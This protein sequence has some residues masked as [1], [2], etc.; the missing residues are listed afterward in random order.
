MLPMAILITPICPEEIKN[1]K[2]DISVQ[3]PEG[4]LDLTEGG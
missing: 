4:D 3:K 1:I 2:A